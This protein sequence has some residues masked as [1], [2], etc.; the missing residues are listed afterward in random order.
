MNKRIII[1]SVLI[2]GVLLTG[3][4]SFA[5]QKTLTIPYYSTPAG[6]P[7][8]T[9]PA[10]AKMVLET[11]IISSHPAY[12]SKTQADLW[13]WISTH[14]DPAWSGVYSGTYSDP[15]ALKECL[16]LYDTRP[17]WTYVIHQTSTYSAIVSQK[18]VYTLQHYEV[19]PAVPIDGGLNWVAVL[20]VNTDVDPSTGPYT[21]NW[22]LIN[23]PRDPILGN[24]RYVSYFNWENN[25][26]SSVFLHI[27]TPDPFPNNMQKLAIC[28][29]KEPGPL[30]IKAPK[31]L[32]RRVKILPPEEAKKAAIKALEKYGLQ[33]VPE[34]EAVRNVKKLG[35]PILVKRMQGD[36]HADYYIVP[37]VQKASGSHLKLTAAILI[38]AY[39]GA[40]L[41]ASKASKPV[42][43]PYLTST[44]DEIRERLSKT[45]QKKESA[46]KRQV[47]IKKA[48]LTWE[49]GL[50]VNPYFP[51]WE[52]RSVVKGVDRIQYM[53]MKGEVKRLPVPVR[54]ID[55]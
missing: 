23:D 8:W 7:N 34:F 12:V 28:D 41:E 31:L 49:P 4:Q 18:I 33:E 46:S 2:L 47:I 6:N 54:K 15:I 9:G 1:I 43:Y 38:D 16:K 32:L 20:G 55:R 44:T 14:L 29:P 39:S 51:V 3:T 37:V 17:G 48:E 27:T 52:T 50:S 26:T 21:I 53:N 35:N 42:D 22:F 45:I 25:G 30:R 11:P 36:I 5:W 40:F 10:T 19:P 13:A 24:N